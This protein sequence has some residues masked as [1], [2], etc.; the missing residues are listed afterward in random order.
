MGSRGHFIL[1]ALFALLGLARFFT[2]GSAVF[3]WVNLGL[4][5]AWFLLGWRLKRREDAT[6]G[7]AESEAGSPSREPSLLE[8]ERQ[9]PGD[10]S[11]G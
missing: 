10:P 9:S 6:A 8:G 2:G 3:G 7:I 5:A 1:G 4:G 11:R